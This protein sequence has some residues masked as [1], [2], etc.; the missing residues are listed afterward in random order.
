MYAVNSGH[1]V[2]GLALAFLASQ[3]IVFF[4][5][6]LACSRLTVISLGFDFGFQKKI[7]KNSWPF[8]FTGLLMV[9]S[10]RH[11]HRNDSVNA[12]GASET[13]LYNSSLRL[14]E[15]LYFIPGAVVSAVF[16]MMSRLHEVDKTLLSRL[17]R[18]AFYYLIVIALPMAIGVTF[19]AE[20]FM[21]FIYG[22]EF[23]TAGTVLKILTWAGVAIFLYAIPGYLLNAINKQFLFALTAAVATL[24]NIALNFVLISEFGY[25]GAA[26]ATTVNA[27]FILSALLYFAGKNGHSFNFI[28]PFNKARYCHCGHVCCFTGVA[29][30]S[31]AV[32]SP[33]C[34][35][36]LFCH[37]DTD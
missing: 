10:F 30:S 27:F 6:V 9:V 22:N 16:P 14:L 23:S 32:A 28:T 34:C 5:S 18:K 24:F 15:A 19:L 11:G 20:R 25:S 33:S 2:T 13:G 7:L 17:Y 1:G 4:I 12:G 31:L 26:I 3:L 35:N 21:L 29:G 37:P 36:D 8:W